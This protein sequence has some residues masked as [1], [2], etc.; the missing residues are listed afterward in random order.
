MSDD[1]SRI[2]EILDSPAS[3]RHFL[4][5]GAAVL[6]SLGLAPVVGATVAEAAS[7]KMTESTKTILNIA[8]TAEA[9]AVT[10]LYHVHEAVNKNQLS[11]K[12]VAVPTSL[13]VSVVRGALREEQDHYA[14]ITGAGGKP[15]YTS[16]SFP[17]A[18]FTDAVQ[19]LRFFE[20][21]ETVFVGA[22]MAATREFA[23][24][25]MGTLAQYTYQIGGVECEH[26]T[27][28]RAALGEM[29]PN[30]KSFET[31]LFKQVSGAAHVLGQLGIFKPNLPYPGAKAVDTILSTS[32]DK[33]V[34][35]G[36]I[37]RSP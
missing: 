14:F 7:K 2:E 5:G 17:K 4:Q 24:A 13:L 18:I 33:H 11:V 31:N 37:Q 34:T 30:N 19:T 36:V 21:A 22:Y 23:N 1:G 8:A 3:R 28:M 26:R 20:T 16:F 27:L 10:A 29:P 9:A 25:G 6:G 32:A 35:A 15:L 12:G